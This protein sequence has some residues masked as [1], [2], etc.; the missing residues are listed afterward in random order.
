MHIRQMGTGA[1]T[2][3]LLPGLGTPL[4]SVEFAPLMRELSK[5]HTVCVVEIFGYGHS[6][7]TDSP[8]TNENHVDEIREGL[9]MAGLQP[10]YV[11]MPFS[12]TGIYSEYYAAKYPS[13]IAGLILLDTTA[14]VESYGQLFAELKHQ[15]EEDFDTEAIDEETNQ[16]YID[17]AIAEY[18]SHGYTPDE[19]QEIIEMT[20]ALTHIDT[21]T[22]Q[23]KALSE[24]IL[25]AASMPI[26]KEIPILVFHA[27]WAQAFDEE[28]LNEHKKYY[29]DHMHRLGE[30][31]KLVVV[32]G[33]THDDIHYHSDCRKVISSEIDKFV[34]LVCD[35]KKMLAI[36]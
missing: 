30:H 18:V 20:A 17:E 1:N 27:D 14:T 12:C 3:V 36:W 29:S 33:S 19:V 35:Q 11:L 21:Q 7:S 15:P 16:F 23:E 5:K 13:E 34:G 31:A 8:R 4:P 28:E 6:D 10:P 24:N 32:K 22:A 25:E 9:K 2:I 26:P